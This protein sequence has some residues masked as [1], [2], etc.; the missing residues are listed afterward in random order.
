MKIIVQKF[1]GTSV[2]TPQTRQLVL[3]KV[4]EALSEGFSPIVVVSAMG[5]RGDPYATDTLIDMLKSVSP[6][7]EAHEMDLMMACGEIISSTVMAATLQ[8]AGLKAKALTGGQAGMITDGNF[9]NARIKTVK[10]QALKAL[11]NEGIIPVICG[12]QGVTDMDGSIT[13]LGR[14]G[15]DTSAAAFGVAVG[16]EKV[17]I[18]TDVDGI[19]TAD[20][21]I[22]SN[23]KIIKKIS[24][25]EIR[26]MAHQGAKVIHPRAVE[27][28][29]RYGVPMVVKSTFSDAP[30]TLIT[31]YDQIETIEDQDYVESNHASGVANLQGL[32]FFQV[33]LTHDVSHNGS[34][35]FDVLAKNGVSIGSLS[36]QPRSLMFAVYKSGAPKA[37]TVLKKEGFTY[38]LIENCAKVTVVGN[39]MGGTP[40]IMARFVGALTDSGVEILQTT[41]SDNLVSAIVFEKDVKTAVNALHSAF[42]SE[43]GREK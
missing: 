11:V 21:R 41:D 37:E 17:E 27:I 29:M 10:P 16:A 1:G 7:P 31:A 8:K 13:T 39:H 23:A 9:G 14:G 6:D 3:K 30:G 36:F 40:G 15:S 18:Y 26:E 5:R 4:Q 22:V 20:P 38:K 33:D 19:M 42:A 35:L 28:V 24:Y 2:A 12:F 43:G 32:S 34:R 25:E